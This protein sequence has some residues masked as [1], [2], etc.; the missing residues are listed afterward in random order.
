MIFP[1][2]WIT[3]PV[4]FVLPEPKECSMAAVVVFCFGK[5]R[6][7]FFRLKRDDFWWKIKGCIGKITWK[8][9]RNEGKQWKSMGKWWEND[10][11]MMGRSPWVYKRRW[12]GKSWESY[13]GLKVACQ[14]RVGLKR[15]KGWSSEIYLR[16][17][18]RFQDFH[19]E[20]H[21]WF[22]GKSTI[23]GL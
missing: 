22:I 1:R 6:W 14:R 19:L 7:C 17:Q 8:M 10:G 3:K 15:Q 20:H 21:Q 12:T 16:R 5:G 23:N 11:R 4:G 18:Q 9:G 2:N 13:T